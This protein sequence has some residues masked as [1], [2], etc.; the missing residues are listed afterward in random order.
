MVLSTLAEKE[1]ENLT[2]TF[3]R[4]R[5]C[6]MSGEEPGPKV[7]VR[8]TSLKKKKTFPEGCRREVTSEVI[9]AVQA[10]LSQ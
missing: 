5:G 7:Y 1:T 4:S 3:L 6:L 10:E 2:V 8:S 9:R